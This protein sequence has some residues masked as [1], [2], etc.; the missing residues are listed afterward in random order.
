MPEELLPY[1]YVGVIVLWFWSKGRRECSGDRVC[2]R[3]WPHG[4]GIDT[5][6]WKGCKG[7]ARKSPER[8][9]PFTPIA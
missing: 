6:T 9:T 5:G 1:I 8:R 3:H 2:R 4:L 7:W